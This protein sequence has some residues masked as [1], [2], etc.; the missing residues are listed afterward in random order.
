M[1][2]SACIGADGK[3]KP[4]LFNGGEFTTEDP[5]VQEHIESLHQFVIGVITIKP[6]AEIDAKVKAQ[7]A[8]LESLKPHQ[9]AANKA[10]ADA[11]AAAR[12]KLEAD[13]AS[14]KAN[15]A[16][17]DARKAEHD[18][19]VAGIQ[20]KEKRESLERAIASLVEQLAMSPAALVMVEKEFPTLDGLREKLEAMLAEKQATA[21]KE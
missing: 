17:E 18:K 14:R 19:I 15:Q 4:N 8:H 5:K 20:A 9:E 11:A 12:K 6:Q 2:S 1:F 10:H 7:A 13:L 3:R 16:A 21:A